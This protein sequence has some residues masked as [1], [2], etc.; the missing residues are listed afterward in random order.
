MLALC[1]M[2][3]TRQLLPNPQTLSLSALPHCSKQQR[4]CLPWSI[5]A[6]VEYV[7]PALIESS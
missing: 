3:R 1:Q 5:A 4:L 2:P 6:S 7:G